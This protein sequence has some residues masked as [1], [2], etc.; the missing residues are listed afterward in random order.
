MPTLE[1][2]KS[3][4]DAISGDRDV[5]TRLLH[6]HG[7]Q[8]RAR[9]SIASTWRA[10]LDLDDVMQVTYMEA[11]LRI[12]QLQTADERTFVAWL[13]R[14]AQ[15]NLRDAIRELTADRRPDPRLRARPMTV[16]ESYVAL[17][18]MLGT[19]SSTPSRVAGRSD[20]QRMIRAAVE[21]LPP[22]Y[23]DVVK[24]CDL[25]H[26][27]ASE[28]AAKMGRSVGA[29]KMLRMRAHDWLRDLLGSGSAFLS[30]KN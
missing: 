21:R 18:A 13:T 9:L 5:L 25:E 26:K 24:L 14:M 6:K 30:Y 28:V 23:R 29:I 7:P 1:D 17:S 16:D 12:K 2:A 27:A 11:F 20:N 10:I 8:V 19:A 22:V 4:S 15:N 3:I